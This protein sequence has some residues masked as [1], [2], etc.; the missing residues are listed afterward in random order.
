MRELAIKYK[1]TVAVVTHNE[2]IALRAERII[3]V[4][5]GRIV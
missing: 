2:E 5:D 3:R 1:Q 4:Q